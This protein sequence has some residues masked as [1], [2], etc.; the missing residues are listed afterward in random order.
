MV[1]RIVEAL[2]ARGLTGSVSRRTGGGNLTINVNFPNGS[3][4]SFYI[5]S[6]RLTEEGMTSFMAAVDLLSPLAALN[7]GEV[8]AHGLIVRG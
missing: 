4:I 2:Q 3:Y 1:D 6:E 8:P 5:P 7:A